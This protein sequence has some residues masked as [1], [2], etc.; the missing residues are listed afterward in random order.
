[1]EMAEGLRRV[2]ENRLTKSFVTGDSILMLLGDRN[3]NFDVASA[4][5]LEG[6]V[7]LR[8]FQEGSVCRLSKRGV[9]L[10]QPNSALP[11][12]LFSVLLGDSETKNLPGTFRY[13]KVYSWIDDILMPAESL[14]F[15]WRTD[16]SE[17]RYES[18]VLYSY[19]EAS[20]HAM[21]YTKLNW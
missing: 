20:D 16:S 3:S 5:I 7:S 1:M 15:A 12:K 19:P 2:V 9:P 21:V 13:K 6:T 8:L 18:G 4:K 17:G 11:Q 10:C 14:R